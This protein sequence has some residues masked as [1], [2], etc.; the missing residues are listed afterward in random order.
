MPEH[1]QYEWDVAISFLSGDKNT[2]R[3]LYELLSPTLNCFFYERDQESIAGRDGMDTFTEIFRVKSRLNVVLFRAGWG[4]TDWTGVEAAAIKDSALHTRYRSAFIAAVEDNSS[5]PVWVPETLLYFSLRQFGI[6]QLA[7]AIR[8]K[9][10]ELGAKHRTESVIE[11]SERLAR[12]SAD[13]NERAAFESTRESYQQL[14]QEIRDAFEAAKTLIRQIAE[15]VGKMPTHIDVDQSTC[16]VKI[17]RISV[18]LEWEPRYQAARDSAL[19]VRV[20]E[21]TP[22]NEYRETF[23][24]RQRETFLVRYGEARTWRWTK[25]HED[26]HELGT[27]ELVEYWVNYAIEEAYKPLKESSMSW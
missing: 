3:E 23:E 1:S 13:A 10:L 8:A 6:Q 25:R 22:E 9:A 7:G 12:R 16:T 18:V 27:K 15:R 26:H 17:G 24:P 5:L 14:A 2:A 20:Y 4:E 19:I 21:L 11:R